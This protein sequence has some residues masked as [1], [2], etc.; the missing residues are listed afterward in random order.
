MN[1]F[2]VQSDGRPPEPGGVCSRSL[3]TGDF[4]LAAVAPCLLCR[5]HL[6]YSQLC[7]VLREASGCDLAFYK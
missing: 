7:K 1:H 2:S 5:D 6:V 3:P 4:F